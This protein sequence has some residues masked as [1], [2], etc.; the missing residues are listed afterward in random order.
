MSAYL[1]ASFVPSRSEYTISYAQKTY[2]QK[3]QFCFLHLNADRP[4]VPQPMLK[5]TGPGFQTHSG[6]KLE[7]RVLPSMK[8]PTI[9]FLKRSIG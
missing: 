2:Q 1:L 8:K 3:I 5:I 7:A 4:K 9:L 6:P